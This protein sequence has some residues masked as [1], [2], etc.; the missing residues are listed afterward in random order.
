MKPLLTKQQIKEKFGES[1]QSEKIK[2]LQFQQEQL[3]NERL[4]LGLE[5]EFVKGKIKPLQIELSQLELKRT[6]AKEKEKLV[7][8]E[9]YDIQI[10]TK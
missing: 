1:T 10:N 5:I 6:A 2:D 3:K 7:S 8:A 9:I 4:N